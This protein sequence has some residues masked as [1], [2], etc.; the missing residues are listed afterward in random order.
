MRLE[1]GTTDLTGQST[2][3]YATDS[4]PTNLSLAK[5]NRKTIKQL[6][7]LNLHF[8]FQELL[9]GNS[10]LMNSFTKMIHNTGF[11]VYT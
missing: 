4:K 9:T 1:L 6:K 11:L 7:L 2:T 3:S 8:N 5:K 10:L